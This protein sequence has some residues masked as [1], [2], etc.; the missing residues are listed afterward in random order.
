[1][2]LREFTDADGRRWEVWDIRPT[3]SYSLVT[4][5]EVE[6]ARGWLAFKSRDGERR[7]LAPIPV[8]PEGWSAATEAQLCSW[9]AEARPLPRIKKFI[10]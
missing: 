6:G 4:E 9:C 5:A 8:A 1:M 10:E 7:R 2:A 3:L